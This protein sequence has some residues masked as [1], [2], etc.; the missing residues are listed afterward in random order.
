MKQTTLAKLTVSVAFLIAASGANAAI[1]EKEQSA[2]GT[3]SA[4]AVYQFRTQ[5]AAR[6]GLSGG[7]WNENGAGQHNWCRTVRPAITE[8]ETKARGMAL[9]KCLNPR[10]SININDLHLEIGT[11]NNQL[12]NAARRGAVERMQQLI[13]AGANFDSKKESLMSIAVSSSK[14]KVIAFLRRFAVPISGPRQNP[15]AHLIGYSEDQASLRYW[16]WL[17]KNGVNVNHTGLYGNTPLYAAISS[18]NLKAVHLLLRYRVNVN[19][20]INGGRCKTI[21]PLDLAIDKGNERI[22]H[23]LRKAGARSQAQCSR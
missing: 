7:R 23:A 9:M 4:K 22:I 2:C 3:Y 11:L 10:G 1:F 17:I 15:L 16:E 21:M 13:A 6:C 20:D 19:L 8:G 18:Q 5:K 14:M 12:S